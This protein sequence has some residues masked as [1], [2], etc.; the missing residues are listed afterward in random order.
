MVMMMIIL[1]AIYLIFNGFSPEPST[2]TSLI[3]ETTNQTESQQIKSNQ[4]KCW[5][6]VKGENRS[7]R[8]KTSQNRVQNQQSQSIY[9][10]G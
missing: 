2:V 4:I 7:T 5:F 1:I 8:R 10:G 6:L 3:K 9:D